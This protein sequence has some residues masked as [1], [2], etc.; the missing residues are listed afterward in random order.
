MSKQKIPKAIREQVWINSF[1]KVFK[2]KCYVKWCGNVIDVFNYHCGHNIPESKGGE[3]SF[4]NLYPICVNCNLG[5]SNNHTIDE[6]SNK[7]KPLSVPFWKCC[8][9]L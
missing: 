3:L 1:G 4:D 5:M 6:W 7:I 8:F 2:H 9:K